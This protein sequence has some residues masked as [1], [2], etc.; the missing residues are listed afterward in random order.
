MRVLT[1][2]HCFVYWNPIHSELY[3]ILRQKEMAESLMK[4]KQS[5]LLWIRIFQTLYQQRASGWIYNHLLW[6]HSTI[7]KCIILE[8]VKYF[9]FVRLHILKICSD[10]AEWNV[11]LTSLPKSRSMANEPKA[12]AEKNHLELLLLSSLLD[13]TKQARYLLAW[14]VLQ[15]STVLCCTDIWS[16]LYP[17]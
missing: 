11:C 6:L 12:N 7:K 8:V 13:Q 17:T 10:I 9:C 2:K 15:P 14:G 4:T 1:T 3:I 16:L 5:S